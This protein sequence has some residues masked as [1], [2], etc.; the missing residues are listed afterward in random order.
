ML[1]TVFS[2][3]QKNI[4][5]FIAF[6]D[7]LESQ[8][9]IIYGIHVTHSSIMSCYVDDRINNHIHFVDGTEGGYTRAAMMYKSK[10]MKA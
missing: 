8:G 5:Q 4:D 10:I 9:K 3:T 2:G 6:I 1:N 7:Q